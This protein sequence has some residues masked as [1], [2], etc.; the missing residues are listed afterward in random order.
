MFARPSFE[1]RRIDEPVTTGA[2]GKGAAHNALMRLC[3]A[4]LLAWSAPH[5][6]P[7]LRELQ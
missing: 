2:L 4:L 3:A 6:G 5:I 7:S 1:P